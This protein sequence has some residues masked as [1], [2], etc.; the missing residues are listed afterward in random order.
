MA[1]ATHL[2]AARNQRKRKGPRS[3]WDQWP[4]CD[5]LPLASSCGLKFL[6]LPEVVTPAGDRVWYKCTVWGAFHSKTGTVIHSHHFYTT[7][8]SRCFRST[9]FIY[10]SFQWVL[11]LR[12]IITSNVYRWR[13]WDWET[14]YMT[15]C[16]MVGPSPNPWWFSLLPL[17]LSLISQL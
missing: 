2:T 11:W 1:E 15:W 4:L 12:Y 10:P 5:L 7:V 16:R 13:G 6:L 8:T 3:S 14:G 9:F 17:W